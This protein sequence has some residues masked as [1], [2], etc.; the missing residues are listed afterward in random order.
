MTTSSGQCKGL[1]GKWVLVTGA[2]RGIGQVVSAGYAAAG[3][4]LVLVARNQQQLQE[5]AQLCMAAGAEEVETYAAD[6]SSTDNIKTL[7]TKIQSK[8]PYIYGLVN[9]AGF[10]PAMNNMGPVVSDVAE[11]QTCLQVNV[12]APMY[13]TGLLVPAMKKAAGGLIVNIGSVAAIDGKGP[14]VA[15]GTTKHAIRGWSMYC[16]QHLS[17][18]NIKVVLINPGLV[19]TDFSKPLGIDA[20]MMLQ[21][22]DIVEAALLPLRMSAQA[23]P[24]EVT[25]LPLQL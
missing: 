19:A 17:K 7:V 9:N 3:A 14:L 16:K 25:V 22:Q 1:S 18:D 20:R 10:V 21:P 13:L 4:C 6:L 2:S 15:Y 11:W 23:V 8:H 24:T 12:M 5:T